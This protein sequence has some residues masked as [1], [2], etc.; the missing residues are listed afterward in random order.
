M[1]LN[2]VDLFML[3]CNDRIIL[4]DIEGRQCEMS[5][6]GINRVPD[7]P[8]YDYLYEPGVEISYSGDLEIKSHFRKRTI[9]VMQPDDVNFM[10][11][12]AVEEYC[13]MKLQAKSVIA[14]NQC[15]LLDPENSSGIAV[16]KTGKSIAVVCSIRLKKIKNIVYIDKNSDIEAVRKAISEAVG[17]NRFEEMNVC[18]NNCSNNMDK[19]NSLG[20]IIDV[21]TM[22]DNAKMIAGQLK[23]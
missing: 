6:S 23:L 1:K 19:F 13:V 8:V 5:I 21:S 22:F 14:I 2:K 16:S 9:Y 20:K 15:D 11:M 12:K 18:L 17:E 4:R 3:L 7:A 10:E